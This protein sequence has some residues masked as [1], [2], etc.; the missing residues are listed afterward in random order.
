MEFV[1]V[2]GISGNGVIGGCL[3]FFEN[4]LYVMYDFDGKYVF[5]EEWI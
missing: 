1:G 3:E 4:F 5:F 2:V